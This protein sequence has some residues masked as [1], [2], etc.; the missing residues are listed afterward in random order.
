MTTTRLAKMIPL[1]F[2]STL[3]CFGQSSSTPASVLSRFAGTWKENEAKAKLG[4]VP[5]L[6]FRAGASG[7]L[8]EVRGSDAA[9]VIEPVHFDGK[10]QDIDSGKATIVWKQSGPDKFE[11][12]SSEGGQLVAT[13]RITISNGGKTLTE[14]TERKRTDGNTLLLTMVYSRSSGEGSGLAGTWKAESRHTNLPAQSTVTVVG[15]NSLKFVNQVGLTYT[16]ALDNKPVP[17]SGPGVISGT[18]IAFRQIDD[19]TLATSSSRNGVVTGTGTIKISP[20]GKVKTIT[21]MNVGPNASKEPSV[22][23]SDKQ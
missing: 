5:G 16:A 12:Q 18:M 4:S 20:D 19:Y 11:R 22:T 7:G 10:Q 1:V 8:E 9:P 23:V 15:T 3:L 14:E 17:E 6:R 21:T 2:A 13:R